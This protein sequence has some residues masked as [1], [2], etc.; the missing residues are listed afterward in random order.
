MRAMPA[1]PD[2]ARPARAVKAACGSRLDVWR[3]PGLSRLHALAG[4]DMLRRIGSHGHLHWL[5]QKRSDGLAVMAAKQAWP[6]A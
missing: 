3:L 4:A 6:D 2:A 5:G 1:G